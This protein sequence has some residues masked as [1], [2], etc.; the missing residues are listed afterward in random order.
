M[1]LGSVELQGEVEHKNTQLL[2]EEQ[3]TIGDEHRESKRMGRNCLGGYM[4]SFWLFFRQ[5]FHICQ[6]K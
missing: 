5:H 3:N 2:C 6:A 4:G 1:N